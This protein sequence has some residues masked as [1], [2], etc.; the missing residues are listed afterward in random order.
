MVHVK[1]YALNKLSK[2]IGIWILYRLLMDDNGMI[3]VTCSFWSSKYNNI[4]HM[5]ILSFE[6]IEFILEKIARNSQNENNL[7]NVL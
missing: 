5:C 7:S 3:M 1:S 2:I 4:R 6:S